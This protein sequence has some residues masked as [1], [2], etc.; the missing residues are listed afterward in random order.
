LIEVFLKNIS[1]GRQEPGH[2][3]PA[4]DENISFHVFLA[5]TS[6]NR[7]FVIVE[8]TLM[9]I[10]ADFLN[11]IPQETR[12]RGGVYQEHECILE[13]IIAKDTVKRSSP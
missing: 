6:R 8:E 1:A 2:G 3:I 11:R 7:V 9:T 12:M 5:K 10:V 13:T 4:F